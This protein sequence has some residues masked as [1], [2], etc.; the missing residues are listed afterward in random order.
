[1]NLLS[2]GYDDFKQLATEKQRMIYYYIGEY[3]LELVVFDGFFLHS[4]VDYKDFEDKP[5]IAFVDFLEGFLDDEFGGI[6]RT[7]L[8]RKPVEL[9]E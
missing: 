9:V 3:W 6:N 4:R 7:R 1:M 2:I 8:I 5:H